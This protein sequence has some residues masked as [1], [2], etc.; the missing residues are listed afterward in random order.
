MLIGLTNTRHGH[1][2]KQ[3]YLEN[4]WSNIKKTIPILVIVR[5]NCPSKWS[6]L[7]K[8]FKMEYLVTKKEYSEMTIA[9]S[10]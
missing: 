8:H 7:A 4:K 3:T 9:T 1:S 5:I 6:K 2:H 10:K